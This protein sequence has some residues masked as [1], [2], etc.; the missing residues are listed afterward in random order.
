[1]KTFLSDGPRVARLATSSASGDIHVVPVW[2]RLDDDRIL[3]HVLAESRK[4]RNVAETG[5]FALV[6][7][8][9]GPPYQGV[10]VKGPARVV[11]ED[12]IDIRAIVRELAIE[13]WGP[14]IGAEYGPHLADAS[15]IH[16]ALV[17]EPKT[18]TSW[19]YSEGA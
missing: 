19:D 8:V 13:H 7:D 5:R 14:E 10:M 6:V 17:L 9:E 11:D 16:V 3:V 4:A 18:W 12:V 1:M 15:G 2:Y